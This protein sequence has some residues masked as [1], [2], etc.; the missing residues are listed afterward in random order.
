MLPRWGSASRAAVTK[1]WPRTCSTSDGST[2]C[3]QDPAP[4]TIVRH[5][6]SLEMEE[7]TQLTAVQFRPMGHAT[8]AILTRQFD[9]QSNQQQTRKGVLQTTSV[10]MIRNGLQTGIQGLQIKHERFLRKRDATQQCWI[11]HRRTLHEEYGIGS[12]F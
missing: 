6:L 5:F 7:L 4:G 11:V 12:S 1:N 8:T 10:P 2:P 9:E 3:P